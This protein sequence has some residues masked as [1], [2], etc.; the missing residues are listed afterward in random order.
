VAWTTGDQQNKRYNLS[1]V[2]ESI[3]GFER[4]NG[5]FYVEA[6]KGNHV[7]LVR[8]QPNTGPG[9]R[10]IFV[11]APRNS[12]NCDHFRGDVPRNSP[13]ANYRFAPVLATRAIP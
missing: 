2:L 13:P 10:Q 7:V 3:R 8:D 4:S 5:T 9:V 6:L 12:S 1:T 11:A